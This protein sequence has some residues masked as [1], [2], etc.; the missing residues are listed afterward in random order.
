[1]KTVATAFDEFMEAFE[2][3]REANSADNHRF[4]ME[5]LRPQVMLQSWIMRRDLQSNP[6]VKYLFGDN[7]ERVGLGGQAK[8]MRGEPNAIGVATKMAP[9][10]GDG[11]FFSDDMFEEQAAQIFCDLEP[12]FE[13]VKNGGFLVIPADGL[14]TGLSEL[15]VRAPMINRYLVGLIDELRE[16]GNS[17]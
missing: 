8:E 5:S 17:L 7:L 14:G 11:D 12:A 10:M 9:G 3:F 1:M 13:H 16:K 2:A 6:R 4:R 15:P